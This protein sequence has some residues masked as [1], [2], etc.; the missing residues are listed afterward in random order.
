[1]KKKFRCSAAASQGFLSRKSRA[2][3]GAAQ[4][5]V[6]V[7]LPAVIGLF[8]PFAPFPPY[9]GNPH[10][11]QETHQVSCCDSSDSWLLSTRR[12]RCL[13]GGAFAWLRS[14]VIRHCWGPDLWW[15]RFWAWTCGRFVSWLPGRLLAHS[16]CNP[17]T[18]LHG[19]NA[20][21]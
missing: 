17:L 4:R 19:T 10:T 13:E 11:L 21:G 5:Q 3:R 14:A 18:C 20:R 9:P 1:M 8:A 12:R 6:G 15:L 7:G 2:A 16:G